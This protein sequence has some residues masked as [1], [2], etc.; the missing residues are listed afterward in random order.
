MPILNILLN[1]VLSQHRIKVLATIIRWV[2]EIKAN[3]IEKEE[4]KLSLFAGDVIPCTEYP[5]E[6]MK[7]VLELIGKFSKVAECKI[8]MQKYIAHLYINSELSKREIKEAT[9]F[10]ITS[11]IIKKKPTEGGK[12]HVLRRL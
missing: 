11:K 1:I 8:N 5:K 12:R 4:V 2:K 7:N 6:A 3:Q 9:P 10:T